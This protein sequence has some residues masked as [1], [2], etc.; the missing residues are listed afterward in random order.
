[1]KLRVNHFSWLAVA[2]LRV[3][4]EPVLGI[5]GLL[6]RDV[7]S[8]RTFRKLYFSCAQ[9]ILVH[10]NGSSNVAVLVDLE[11]I[12]EFVRRG[13]KRWLPRIAEPARFSGFA[14]HLGFRFGFALDAGEYQRTVIL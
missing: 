3:V 6:L 8:I 13:S 10:E 1:G 2:G 9:S 7:S 4:D 5:P 12:V 11:P 14:F